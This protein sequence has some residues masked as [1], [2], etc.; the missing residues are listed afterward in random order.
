MLK[1]LLLM[2]ALLLLALTPSA[3][4]AQSTTFSCEGSLFDPDGSS[5]SSINAT[6]TTGS[7][8]S[9]DIGKGP[10]QAS[11]ISNNRIQFKFATKDS[12]GEYFY[13]TRD[14]F[15][16]YKSGHLARLMCSPR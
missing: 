6:L 4:A 10:V 2:V 9:I 16:I 15:L 3:F 5:H 14:L 7:P 11:S 13:Y 8:W 1:T 12:T